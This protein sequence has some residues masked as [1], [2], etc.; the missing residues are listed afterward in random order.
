MLLSKNWHTTLKTKNLFYS[1][2]NITVFLLLLCLL[3]LFQLSRVQCS[4]SIARWLRIL[5]R[6]ALYTYR[7]RQFH[8]LGFLFRNLYI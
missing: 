2:V 6:E 1:Y 4:W 7:S 8:L 5:G 3:G